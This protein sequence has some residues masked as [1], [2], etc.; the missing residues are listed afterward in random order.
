MMSFRKMRKWRPLMVKAGCGFGKDEIIGGGL[1]FS[2]FTV[3]LASLVLKFFL[4]IYPLIL[5][6]LGDILD[7][8]EDEI[9]IL[10]L[11]RSLQIQ[12]TKHG[13]AFCR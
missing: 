13:G 9:D 7:G 11:F 12:K 10:L 8:G 3:L 6:Q 4:R 2:P 1:I 5:V